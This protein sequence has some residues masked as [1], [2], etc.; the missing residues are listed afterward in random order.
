M[1]DES[2]EIAVTDLRRSPLSLIDE[3]GSVFFWRDQVLRAVRSEAIERVRALFRSGLLDEMANRGWAPRCRIADVS[4]A[5]YALVIEQ[6]RV[7]VVSYP[8]E[9]S[10]GMLRD[11]AA[12]VLE[13]NLLARSYGWELKD[14]HGLN[15]V[16]DGSRPMWVDLGSFVPCAPEEQGWPALE[17]FVRFYEYPLRIWSH[18][19]GFI[20]RR[21]VAAREL[22]SHADYGLYRWPWLRCGGAGSYQKWIRRYFKLRRL[23]RIPDDKIRLRLPPKLGMLVCLFKSS[24][25]LPGQ[26]VEYSRMRSRLQKNIRR[27]EGGAWSDYQ[28]AGLKSVSTSRFDQ[29]V[30]LV[31]R[32]QVSSIV[33]LAGNQGWFSE[34]L[35]REGAVRSA[36]C[37]DAD[38]LSIDR[39]FERTKST[40]SSLCTAVLDFIFPMLNPGELDAPASRFRADA[41][42][43]LAVT[44]HLF[45][46]QDMPVERVLK[47]IG[48]YA[49]RLVFIEFMPLGLWNGE[50]APAVP[51]WYT[52]DWFKNAFTNEFTI[53]HEEM[54]E[55]NR[56][57][58]CGELRS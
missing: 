8:Y 10:Y 39:A 2:V 9:W 11:A 26:K 15:I 14:S 34:R 48:A 25:W 38:E 12:R 22:M 27:N 40:N 53:I 18:G 56:Y 33:E 37:T 32:F 47:T 17:E 44:H 16:F 23:S 46:T 4:I 55:P 58:F 7:P 57:L 28:A 19:G 35:L 1:N 41:V 49:R 24:R 3:A 51:E 6:V 29:I 54:L 50:A 45:L 42:L 36:I 20:A 43:A 5:G 31:R 30:E 21:L 13:I 52:I